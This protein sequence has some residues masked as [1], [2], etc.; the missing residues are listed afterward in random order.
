MADIFI[1]DPQV[2]VRRLIKNILTRRG[3]N[4]Y[5]FATSEEALDSI[6]KGDRPV[7]MFLDLKMP[8][9]NGFDFIEKLEE[10]GC[11]FPIVVVTE[12]DKPDIIR[13]AFIMGVCDFITKPFAPQELTEAFENCVRAE[14]G[15]QKRVR[16][17]EKLIKDEKIS[18]ATREIRR[19]IK[20]FPDSPYP[21]YLF[22][23]VSGED[24]K[25]K[26]LKAALALDE[27]FK[28][29]RELLEKKEEKDNN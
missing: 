9:M 13:K 28:E 19:L 16:Q 4:I 20:D 22:A 18:K 15:L 8:K 2:N 10:L 24:K 29:A 17:I 27:N 7:L 25:T 26:H 21:H 12:L 3:H 5:T 6:K 14:E 23:L 11:S 1:V